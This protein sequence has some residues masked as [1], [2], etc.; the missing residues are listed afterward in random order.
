MEWES[1]IAELTSEGSDTFHQK[2]RMEYSSFLTLCTIM[3]PQVQVNDEMSR[4]RTGKDSRTVSMGSITV[5]MMLDC[6]YV[7]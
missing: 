2:Y 1:H 6:F 4:C 5:E 3:S 7:G